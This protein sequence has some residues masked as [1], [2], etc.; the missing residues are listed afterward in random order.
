[1]I[2]TEDFISAYMRSRSNKRKSADQA[3]FELHWERNLL[4]LAR[5]VGNRASRPSA[6]MFI[7]M[8]PKPREVFASD[9][10]SR[11]LHHYLDMRMRP[12]MEQALGGHTFNN[13]AGMG[14]VACQNA[15]IDDM[16]RVSRGYAKDAW[17]IK[18]DLTGCFPN[19]VRQTA[20][21]QMERLME[22]YDGYD[23]D[24]L[25][26]ILRACVLTPVTEHCEIRSSRERI[27]LIPRYK[28]VFS[29]PPGIGAC[30]GF[31]VW[32]NAVNLYFKPVNDWLESEGVTYERYVDDWAFVTDDKEAF[33]AYVLPQLRRR[34]AQLGASMNERKFYCQHVNKGLEW[35]GAHI[36]P[37]RSH[38]NARTVRTAV[39]RAGRLRPSADN[40][41]YA[42]AVA[43]SYLGMCRNSQS[44]RQAEKIVAA[45]DPGWNEYMSFDKRTLRMVALAPYTYR[46]RL[47]GKYNLKSVYY[48]K[49]REGRGPQKPRRKAARAAR[50]NEEE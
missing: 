4:R 7:A 20:Y 6:Y 35:L 8:H 48:D 36:K 49:R 1:M 31:L 17:A 16:E 34:F 43:N 18:I 33:L 42:I 19:V 24:E 15:L 45:L 39:E 5:D 12:R 46:N 25:M 21:E 11:I 40:T 9:M 23:R 22:G 26:Y 44:F 32:Q 2:H 10:G 3:E 13:R 41:G 47:I 14:Q 50:N 37:H 29:K 28:S 30:L 38:L 27:S